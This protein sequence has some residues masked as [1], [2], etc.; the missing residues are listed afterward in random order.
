MLSQSML[1][2]ISEG[3]PSDLLSRRPDIV[4]AEHSLKAANSNIGAARAAFFPKIQLTASAGSS[5]TSLSGLFKAGSGAWTF[6]PSITVPIFDYGY[7]KATLDVAKIEKSIQVADYEK[8]IQTAF[9]EVANAL[10]GRATYVTQTQADRDYVTAAQNY[11][12][13]AQARYQH[14]TDNFLTLL[15]AQRSLYTAQQQLVTDTLSQLSN[16][17]TLYKVLGGGW[18]EQSATADTAALVVRAGSRSVAA[19]ARTVAPAFARRIAC[20]ACSPPVQRR[21]DEVRSDSVDSGAL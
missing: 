20:A 3:L 1:A 16:L 21:D 4:E 13:I 5:S 2:D 8:A 9:K 19:S 17:I 18:S 14:G 15:D 10:A 11:Y 7:N 12:D 6:S